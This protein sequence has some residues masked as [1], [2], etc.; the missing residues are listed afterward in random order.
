[1][2]RDHQGIAAWVPSE[3]PQMGDWIDRVEYTVS[4]VLG[5]ALLASGAIFGA[6]LLF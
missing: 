5:Y 1:M 6:T 3:T 2:M 4:Q